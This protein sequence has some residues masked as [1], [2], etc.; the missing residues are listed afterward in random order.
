MS[1]C[2]LKNAFT[3]IVLILLPLSLLSESLAKKRRV[4]IAGQRVVVI[5]E[6]L[7][8]LR[9]APDLSAPLKQRLGRG[10]TVGIVG[11]KRAPDGTLFYRVSLT[12]NT[13]GW[14][15]SEALALS[16]RPGDDE[17]FMHLIQASDEFERIAR[18]HV[19][20]QTFPRSPVRPAL[21]LLVGDSAEEAADKLSRDATRKLDEGEMAATGASVYSYYMNYNGLDRY[22]KNGIT[23]VFDK[24][25]K[26]YHYDGASWREILHR[27]PQSPEAAEARK[28]LDALAKVASK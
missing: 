23:F 13:R 14:V 27:Y 12:R 20:L 17:R 26:K 4:F 9:D 15:Q 16:G 11:S 22:N 19:F 28:H 18:A 24:T 25:A 5:D 1:P 3:A 10:R 7:A 2:R 6:R 8:A 21:L